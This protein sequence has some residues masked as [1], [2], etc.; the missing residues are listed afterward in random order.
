MYRYYLIPMLEKDISF[1]GIPLNQILKHKQP[2]L[3]DREEERIDI[4]Y[5]TSPLVRMPLSEEIRYKKH[6]DDTKKMYHR[7]GVPYCI[8]A[9]GNE[10]E[11]REILTDAKIVPEYKAALGIR[12]INITY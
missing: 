3:I 4:L 9:Y 12:E 6:N 8:I 1:N 7:L 5:S 2:I 10:Y 11:A